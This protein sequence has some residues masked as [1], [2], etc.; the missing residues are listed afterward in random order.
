M[1]EPIPPHYMMPK[2]PAFSGLEDPETHLKAFQA[3]MLISGGSDA[4]RCKV[5]Q[6]TFTRTT[7]KWFSG[8]LDG[9]IQS[10]QE[11]SQLFGEQFA[12]NVVKPPRMAD[13]FDVRKRE[14]EPLKEYLN[15]FCEISVCV[16]NPQD[17][18]VI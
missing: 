9:T 11:F 14:G 2:M 16:H 7:L 17:K 13:L 3:Q 15:R 1:E 5:L 8:L 12:A 10:F 4:I 6:G 18:M